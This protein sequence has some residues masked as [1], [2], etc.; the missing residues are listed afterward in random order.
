MFANGEA[1]EDPVLHPWTLRFDAP[2]LAR[3][4]HIRLAYYISLAKVDYFV[5]VATSWKE[6]LFGSREKDLD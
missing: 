5:S 1:A 4:L 3:P 2:L 6:E